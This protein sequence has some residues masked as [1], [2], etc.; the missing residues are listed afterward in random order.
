MQRCVH[1][2]AFKL[3]EDSAAGVSE[4]GEEAGSDGGGVQPEQIHAIALPFGLVPLAQGAGCTCCFAGEDQRGGREGDDA[5][6]GGEDVGFQQGLAQLP[7]SGSVTQDFM[8]SL[9]DRSSRQTL[10]DLD[11][12][13]PTAAHNKT[14]VLDFTSGTLML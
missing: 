11:E 8:Y 10:I 3:R 9:R 14:H 2:S 12:A 7:T 1:T 5:G 4:G 6:E 13:T